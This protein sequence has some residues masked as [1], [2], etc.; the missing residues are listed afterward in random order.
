MSR[1]CFRF[2]SAS[3]RVPAS[4]NSCSSAHP[5]SREYRRQMERH[6]T[7]LLV[8]HPPILEICRSTKVSKAIKSFATELPGK[9]RN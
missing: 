5:G 3:L 2:C 7:Q 6:A 9:G 1:P 4:Q 8:Q